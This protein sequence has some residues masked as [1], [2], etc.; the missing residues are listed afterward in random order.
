MKNSMDGNRR[1][2]GCS[3][4]CIS[5]AVV[6]GRKRIFQ[7][8]IANFL[9]RNSSTKRTAIERIESTLHPS[10]MKWQIT[11]MSEFPGQCVCV[12]F[13]SFYLSPIRPPLHSVFRFSLVDRCCSETRAETLPDFCER[14][15]SSLSGVHRPSVVYEK[16][17]PQFLKERKY[18][19]RE[20][21]NNIYWVVQD[22]SVGSDGL[23]KSTYRGTN[24][25]WSEEFT[26]V[27]DVSKVSF[28]S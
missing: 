20:R 6:I 11:V 19:E 23:T 8:S 17:K 3:S 10:Q 28:L 22:I 9:D 16:E 4:S 26:D 18:G 2:K 15:S 12:S 5:L 27:N 13:S 24:R 1:I 14:F 7:P 21:D 25:I